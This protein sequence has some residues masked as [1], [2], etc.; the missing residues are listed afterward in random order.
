MQP[1]GH[2]RNGPK[3]GEGGSAPFWAGDAGADSKSCANGDSDGNADVAF[4]NARPLSPTC[5]LQA[6]I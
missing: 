5:V 2:N 1:F 4:Q 6:E 3:I